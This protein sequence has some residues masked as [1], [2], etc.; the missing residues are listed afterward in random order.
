[1]VRHI[2]LVASLALAALLGFCALTG[3]NRAS[4]NAGFTM[5]PPTVTTAPV[6]VADVPVYLDEIGKTSSSEVVNIVPQVS[7]KIVARYFTDGADLQKGEKLY[8]IDQRPYQAA[9]DQAHAM[10]QQSQ[11]Q[12]ANAKT[13]FDRVAS[14]LPSKAVSQQDYDN[15]KNAVDVADANVKSAQ[16]SVETAQ[17]NLEYCSIDSPI[18]GRASQRLVDA[19]NVVTGNLT[20]LLD[21]QK[22]TPI[23]VDFTVAENELDRVRENLAKGPL[24]VIVQSPN[25]PGKSIDGELTFLD[26]AVQDGTGTIKLRATVPNQDRQLWP[27]Q[28]VRVQ[29][30]LTTLKNAMLVPAEALQVGQQ[31]PFVFAVG[32]KDTAEQ[33]SVVPGQRQGDRIVIEK[34]LSGDEIIVRS[35]QMM[36]IAG[37]PVVVKTPATQPAAGNGT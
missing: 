26:N 10:L 23:Y 21:I 25:D 7:G 14:E 27:G 32:P 16:A 18:D 13:N 34:G 19:G 28:F 37:A 29:L 24:K 17:L 20:S 30:I 11:A 9:L 22:I 5:P 35:G 3:C 4:G 15:A 2:S 12:L 36:L 33:I 8:L 1:M 6:V 31:G